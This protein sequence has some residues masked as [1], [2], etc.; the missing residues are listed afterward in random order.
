MTDIR[1]D[2]ITKLLQEELGKLDLSIDVA[3]IG[4]VIM[5]GDGIARG[6]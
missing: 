4:E 5:V 1:T 3:E 6:I 2:E